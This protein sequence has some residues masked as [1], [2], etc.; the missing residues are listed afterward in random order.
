MD[1]FTLELDM[2][3]ADKLV[4]QNLRQTLEML[5]NTFGRYQYEHLPPNEQEIYA[6]IQVVIRHYEERI[7]LCSVESP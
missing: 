2:E 5:E 6:A 7:R 3:Q 4:V 1:N